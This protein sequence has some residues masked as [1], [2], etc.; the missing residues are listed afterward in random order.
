[1]VGSLAATVLAAGMRLLMTEGI[2]TTTK[3][4]T[5]SALEARDEKSDQ[6]TSPATADVYQNKEDFL[7]HNARVDYGETKAFLLYLGLPKVRFHV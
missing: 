1:M 4:A 3:N 2:V 6:V 7:A 5:K